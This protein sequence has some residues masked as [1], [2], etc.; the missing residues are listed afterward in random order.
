MDSATRQLF[1]SR[2]RV[3]KALAHP[4]RLFIVD[5]L[6]RGERCVCALRDLVGAD[7]STVSKHLAVLK[8]AGI[9]DDDKRGLQVW[10]R[11]RVPCILNFFGC[12][13]EVL[14]T[15]RRGVASGHE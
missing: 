9:V 12:V 15:H 7:I 8:A 2:A 10:Y 4:T 13:E 1:A 6:S 14:R 11:L 3:I 5:E